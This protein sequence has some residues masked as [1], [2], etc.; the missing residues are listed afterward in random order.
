MKTWQKSLFIMLISFGSLGLFFQFTE[1]GVNRTKSLPYQYFLIVKG[2]SFEKGDLVSI[3][4]HQAKYIGELNLIKRVVGVA[5]DEIEPL[6]VGLKNQ[7]KKGEPLTPLAIK[8]IPEGYV[9][10]NADHKHS[11]DSR[12]EEFGLVSVETIHGRAFAFGRIHDEK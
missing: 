12:Y 3:R 11:Y 1:L 10:V 9:F 2:L 6:L 5:G 7:T 4:G 8:V